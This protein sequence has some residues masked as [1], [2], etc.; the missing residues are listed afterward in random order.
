MI[1]LQKITYC[2]SVIILIFSI[3][4]YLS[5]KW[6]K[7]LSLYLLLYFFTWWNIVGWTGNI[8]SESLSM[9]LLFLWFSII[10]LYYRSQSFTNL[11]LLI[12]VSI[13]LAF[14]RDTWPYI[15]LAF[16]II[17]LFFFI[18][19]KN[20]SI[21]KNFVIFIFSIA[22]FCIQNST[23]NLGERYKL[24]VFNSIVG[25]ISQNNDYIQWFK[26]EGMPMTENI[27]KDFRGISIDEH[28]N[29]QKVY[30][31]YNDSTYTK[32]FSWI[33]R[34]GKVTYQ[35]FLL[36][37]W[38]YFFLFDQSEKQNKRIFCSNLSE[39]IQTPK[40]FYL[41]A[42]KTFPYFTLSSTIFFLVIICF[43][44]IKKREKILFFPILLFFLFTINALISYNADAL[45]VK[46]H[47]FIT[48]IV[49]E[50][51]NIISLILIIDNSKIYFTDFYKNKFKDRFQ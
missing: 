19:Y 13:F 29:R 4:N 15:I 51:I 40:G 47:L 34:D 42:D 12:G 49:L 33:L 48:Q 45:E 14:T 23:S 36:T 46:R 8:L 6:I 32:L 16:S 43:L 18:F 22:L 10:L 17:N 2:F 21:K 7:I 3:L 37:H 20:I 35:K 9:S 5:N 24:P 25:R 38:S 28:E 26:K 44:L 31:K 11:F 50:F 30:S 41:N 27:T 1:L 39:Y